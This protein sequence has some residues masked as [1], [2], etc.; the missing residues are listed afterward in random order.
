MD[1]L[2][3]GGYGIYVWSSFALA[4]A[5]LAINEWRARRRFR[6]VFREVEVRIKALEDHL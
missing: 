2:A 5:V 6:R 3:M 4:F 1:K